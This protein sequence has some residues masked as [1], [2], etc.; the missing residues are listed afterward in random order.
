ME[1]GCEYDGE[2]ARTLLNRNN[3]PLGYVNGFHLD[4]I[5][6]INNIKRSNK[7][8]ITGLHISTHQD[9]YCIYENLNWWE[10]RNVDMDTL[11]K[12]LMFDRRQRKIINNQYAISRGEGFAIIIDKQKVIG[13]YINTIHDKI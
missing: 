9:D 11:S 5:N 12:T 13:H 10:Q 8:K 3:T 4:L 2:L 6:S 7:L 1:L